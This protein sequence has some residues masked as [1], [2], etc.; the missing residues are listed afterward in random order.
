M[1]SERHWVDKF[2]LTEHET[3]ELAL[4]AQIQTDA[5]DKPLEALR[6]LRQFFELDWR[7]V[8]ER[9]ANSVGGY[10]VAA[11][12]TLIEQALATADALLAG[13]PE[14]TE[15]TALEVAERVR[16]A[17]ADSLT[18]GTHVG[19]R[20]FVANFPLAHLLAEPGAADECAGD[21]P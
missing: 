12:I 4:V 21:R 7:R 3:D 14:R 9:R 1:K 16:E 8:I 5:C 13:A 10:E 2:E 17:I 19:L 6:I 15:P 20:E 18:D 11:Q